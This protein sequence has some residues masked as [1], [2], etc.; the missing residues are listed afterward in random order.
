MSV[1]RDERMLA[2][3]S[4][5]AAKA[6]YLC[7]TGWVPMSTLT[8][9]APIWWRTPYKDDEQRER[10]EDDAVHHQEMKDNDLLREAG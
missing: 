1:S 6:E 4:F 9:G 10:R 8:P 2:L 7:R 5:I 3:G